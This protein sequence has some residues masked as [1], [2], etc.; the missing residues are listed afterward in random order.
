MI[1]FYD[2]QFVEE[3]FTHVPQLSVYTS[4]YFYLAGIVFMRHKHSGRHVVGMNGY[5]VPVDIT[6]RQK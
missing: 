2:F 3:C 1:L 4:A 6:T 5:L